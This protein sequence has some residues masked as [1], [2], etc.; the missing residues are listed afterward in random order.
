M[1]FFYGL[2]EKSYSMYRYPT[3]FGISYESDRI[4]IQNPGEKYGT[5]KSYIFLFFHLEPGVR[6]G[7]E[8]GEGVRGGEGQEEGSLHQGEELPGQALPLQASHDEGGK[9]PLGK[10]AYIFPYS[11]AHATTF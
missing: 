9:L 11:W 8:G 2:W 1:V 5:N 6:A 10:Y 3:E 7:E 4:W